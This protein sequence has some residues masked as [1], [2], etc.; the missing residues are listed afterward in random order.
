M[1]DVNSNTSL[2]DRRQTK[3]VATSWKKTT[4]LSTDTNITRKLQKFKAKI[5]MKKL[6]NI[7][8]FWTRL[9]NTFYAL[10]PIIKCLR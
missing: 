1:K 2:N 5:S 4:I 10:K 6:G 8:N 7:D 3:F 9:V